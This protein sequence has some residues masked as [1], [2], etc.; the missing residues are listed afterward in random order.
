MAEDKIY[1]LLTLQQQLLSGNTIDKK[2]MANRFKVSEKSLQRDL[3]TLRAYYAGQDNDL[4]YDRDSDR[5]R[6]EQPAEARLTKSEVL[7]VCKILLE[8]RAFTE[9]E[10]GIPPETPVRRVLSARHVF[11]HLEWEMQGYL[12]ELSQPVEGYEWVTRQ[13]LET[14]ISLPSAF[15]VFRR[16]LLT[17]K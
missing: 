17:G 15:R 4:Q 9:A 16:F 12:A 2:A 5:Y 8:S 14:R 13:E 3:E 7:A 10:L 1:R 6:L 11:T